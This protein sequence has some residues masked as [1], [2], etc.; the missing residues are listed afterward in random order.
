MYFKD[1][2]EAGQQLA[3]ALS[4]YKKA[5][6]TQIIALPRGGVVIGHEVAKALHL[7]LDVIIPRKIGAPDNPELAIGA[8]AGD[9]TLLDQDLIAHYDIPR[10]YIDK[11]IA[12]EQWEAARRLTLY[13]KGKPPQNFSGQTLILIDDGIATGATIRASIAYLKKMK[14]AHLIIAVPIAPPDTLERLKEEVDEVV[15]LHAPSSF[16]AVGQF[17]AHFPQTEDAEVI[18]LLAENS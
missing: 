14:A 9:I 12:K 15:C 16:M 11:T 18:Q 8:L 5:P 10:S 6:N 4:K 13:R 3:K 7:P 17:Y 1:R 2:K